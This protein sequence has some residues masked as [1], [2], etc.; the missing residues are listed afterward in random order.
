MPPKKKAA[1]KKDGSAAKRGPEIAEPDHDP[2]WEQV[3]NAL[4]C[5]APLLPVIP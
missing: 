2:R 1:G 3:C 5:L 4:L